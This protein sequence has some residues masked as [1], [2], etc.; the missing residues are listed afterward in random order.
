MGN[1]K[2]MIFMTAISASAATE[3][4]KNAQF[5]CGIPKHANTLLIVNGV[6]AKISDWPWHAAIRQ[7]SGGQPEYV[8]GGTLISERFVL[9]AA[10]CTYGENPNKPP[11]M[12]VL[13]GVNAVG[14]PDGQVYNVEKIHRNPGFTLEQLKDDIAL[15]ELENPVRFSDFVLPI[16]LSK[17]M[18]INPG[19]VGA[20]VGWGYTEN[21]I[22]STKLKLAKLPV[23][24]ELDCKKKEVELYSKVLTNRV[25]CAGYG[26]GTSPCNGDSG[27]GIAFE[28]GDAWYLGGIVSFTKPRDGSSLCSTTTYTVFTKVN[29]YL[30]WISQITNTDF[31]NEYGIEKIVPCSTP[32]QPAGECVP[33]QQCRNIFDSLRSPLLSKDAAE[34]LRRSVCQLRGIRRS[35][36]CEPNQVERIP[37]HRNAIQLPVQCGV[38][39]KTTP[40]I[41]GVKAGIYEFPWIAQIRASRAAPNKDPYCTGSLINARYVLTSGN[42]LKAKEHKDL[43]YVRLGERSHNVPRDCDTVNDP[44]T[45]VPIQECA[46]APLDVRAVL[47]FTIHPQVNKPFRANDFGLVRMEQKVQFTDFIRPLCLPIR[48]A[49]RSNLPNEFILSHYE[50]RNE[51]NNVWSQELYKTRAEFTEVEECEERYE[52]YSYTPWVKDENFCALSKGP[53]FLCSPHSGAPL[54]ALVREGDE[55]RAIHYGMSMNGVSNCTIGRT[56]PKVYIRTTLFVDWILENIA[57]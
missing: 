55:T 40:T 10:H 45:G 34:Q 41:T 13:L 33:V 28:K 4:F 27:G 46:A 52:D 11:K 29:S 1:W 54:V 23:V 47:P 20:V 50:V 49:V 18:E 9:T 26:N 24:G 15:L 6:D 51:G 48:A 44:R 25:F 56:I 43:D 12:S 30:D 42:C 19:K 32:N 31:S 3:V 39:A 21:D 17:R 38:A 35:V 7:Y 8:C 14:S 53:Q 36:C 16:C 57:P 5:Q 37:I 22:P 2:W